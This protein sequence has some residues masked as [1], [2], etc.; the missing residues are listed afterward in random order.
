MHCCLF[1]LCQPNCTC[2]ISPSFFNTF[3]LRS[4]P[5]SF[6]QN[7]H[8]GALSVHI[9]DVSNSRP[10]LQDARLQTIFYY[11]IMGR[12]RRVHLYTVTKPGW[13][14]LAV[15]MKITLLQSFVLL[16]QYRTIMASYRTPSMVSQ[17]PVVQN[18]HCRRCFEKPPILYINQIEI[19]YHIS[20]SGR[21]QLVELSQWDR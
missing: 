20:I 13:S 18:Q 5:N 7:T 11:N 8:N 12:Y 3:S 16:H 2:I 14:A 21:S 15:P 19:G 1:L 6:L 17:R 9:V 10:K 4:S